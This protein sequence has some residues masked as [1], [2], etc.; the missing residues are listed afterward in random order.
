MDTASNEENVFDISADVVTS[1]TEFLATK[2]IMWDF[3][4]HKYAPPSKQIDAIWHAHILFDLNEYTRLFEGGIMN[5]R[6]IDDDNEKRMTDFIK[7]HRV[8]FPKSKLEERLQNCAD[9]FGGCG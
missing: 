5:H 3:S 8:L 1:Y 4:T 2:K 9:F 6:T 7:E